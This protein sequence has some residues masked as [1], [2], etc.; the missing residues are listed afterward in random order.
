MAA[1]TGA[2]NLALSDVDGLTRALVDIDSTT[3][4]EQEVGAWLSGYL[5]DRGYRVSEQPIADGRF[6][7]FAQ[8]DAAARVV[9]STHVDCVPPHVRSR[10]EGG[11]LFGLDSKCDESLEASGATLMRDTSQCRAVIGVRRT[12]G[13]PFEVRGRQ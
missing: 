8:L 9:F 1:V 10:Q 4:R 2:S 12:V 7:V 6:N 3:G 11:M 5:R 13:S